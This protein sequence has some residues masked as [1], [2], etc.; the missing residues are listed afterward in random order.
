MKLVEIL[1]KELAEWPGQ[2][3]ALGISQDGNRSLNRL[4]RGVLVVDAAKCPDDCGTW[5]SSTWTRFSSLL[6]N[7]LASDYRTA[8]VTRAQ[9][10]AEKMKQ[11]KPDEQEDKWI[12]N[13][14]GSRPAAI[15]DGMLIDVR[16]RNGDIE[17]GLGEEQYR[18][19]H[20]NGDV[21]IMAWRPH[22]AEQQEE[23][24]QVPQLQVP[25]YMMLGYTSKEAMKEAIGCEALEEVAAKIAGDNTS[26]I[27]PGK[28]YIVTDDPRSIRDR[29]REIDTT[30]ESL[31]EERASLIQRLEDEGFK[32]V[33]VDAKVFP[34]EPVAD[35]SDWRNWKE[36][37]LV[38]WIKSSAGFY[39]K[40]KHYKVEK[41]TGKGLTMSDDTTGGHGWNSDK[42]I[43]AAFRWN[44]R[45]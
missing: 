31:E 6:P 32:L 20:D 36:G 39:T 27:L 37:D 4:D 24:A 38:E 17:R 16:Y 22:K 44:S 7:T 26:I 45:P 43:A 25:A 42:L 28:Q 35:M 11:A 14:G 9:W 15:T 5:P 8:I 19:T 34:K 13:R 29:I 3:G 33:R 23:S 18:F 21:D 41:V 1:A 2:H 30:V 12:R 10:E 40:G